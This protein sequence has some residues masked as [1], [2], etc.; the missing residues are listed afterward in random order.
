M[1]RRSWSLAF[2]AL[3]LAAP[4]CAPE[5]PAAAPPLPPPEPPPAPSASASAA[6][7]PSAAPSA[8]AYAGHGV[9]SV[10]PEVLA[11]FAPKPIPPE[12]SRR[13]QAMLD[14]RAP[15]AGML[16][17][18]ADR[19]FFT[20]AVTGVRQ[21][22]R[23]DGPQRF[24]VELTGGEDA[25]SI[26]AVT[27]DGKRLVL[28]RD[29]NGEE[30]PGLYLQSADGGP[31]VEI[32]HKSGVQTH[33][34]GLTD[35]GKALYFRSNDVKPS[36]H[37]IYRYD[38]ASGQRE[39]LVGEEGLW[40]VADHRPDGRLLL[41]KEVGSNMAEIYEW[42]PARKAPRALFGQG[43]REDYVVGYG[44]EEGEILVLTPMLGEWRRLYRRTSAGALEP[45]TPEMKADVT[46]FSIDR[47]RTKIVCTV[48]DGGR[49]RLLA[50]DA[51][52]KKPLAL[53]KL[54]DADHVDLASL[55]RD[56]RFATLQVDT[57]T[58]PPQAYVLD[59]KA[60][61]LTL[62]H[63]PS[64]PEIDTKTFAR[65][66]LSSYKARDGVS[67]PMF[68]RKP[69]SCPG[70]PCPVI[71]AFHGG[72]EGQAVPGFS[73]RAQLFVDAGFVY[74]EPNVR[75]S[76]G[77]GKTWLHADDGPKRLAVIT[78]IEDA[79]K[80]ARAAFA[81]GGKEPK[82]GVFGGSYGGYSTLVAMTLFAGAYD[83]GAS[84]VG[85]ANLRTFLLNTAPYRR[86]LR[87]SEYGDPEKDADAL[88]KL[89]PITYVDRL[90]APLLLVQGAS[91]PRVPV[92][93][94]VQIHD[95]LAAKGVDAPLVVFA[96]EGHGAQKRGNV[97]LQYGHVLRFFQQH[98]QGK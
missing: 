90:K 83:A 72:P 21:V 96:D 46:A 75:G 87:I 61:K 28:S 98:L 23:L 32:Q 57:G 84:V 33:F 18:K 80:H 35:D 93:E 82:V 68:V 19:L 8:S 3:A 6:P 63:T 97:V 86:A 11:R 25:T 67:I 37:A 42:D 76:E 47:A 50:F 95:A 94:A 56:G 34:Q 70:G 43:E 44:A 77:Y 17:P 39:L 22:W 4:A 91:D 64:T 2:F 51:R 59:W 45:I 79:A 89:S 10:P 26:A 71:V 27:L 58:A 65:A 62:W 78:D 7:A 52:T 16:A 54:P 5:V 12:L 36:S 53:P 92:G 81:E 40:I 31:L 14:V 13:I 38:L 74:A 9:A 55:S 24:P 29:R 48:N 69:A 49:T 1:V 66:T 60:Q 41:A 73:T 88:A 85:I 15:G 20:W 30:N